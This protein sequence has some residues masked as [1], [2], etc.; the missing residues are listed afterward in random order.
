MTLAKRHVGLEADDR[1]AVL[2]IA[3]AAA[4]VEDPSLG[5]ARCCAP[6]GSD[7]QRTSA[8]TTRCPR[9]MVERWLTEALAGVART[10]Q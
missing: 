2:G 9:E 5:G 3:W 7:S 10:L 8:R 6:G 1:R 4:L